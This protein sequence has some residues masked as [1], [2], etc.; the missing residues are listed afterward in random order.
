MTHAIFMNKLGSL[1]ETR[2]I[3]DNWSEKPQELGV[4]I[5]FCSWGLPALETLSALLVLCVETVEQGFPSQRASDKEG[6]LSFYL[7]LAWTSYWKK[8][9][10]PVSGGTITLTILPKIVSITRMKLE[11]SIWN[12][13][14]NAS[15][16]AMMTSS[17]GNI[18]R[19]TGPLCGDFTGLRWIPRTKASDAEL[20]CFLW[21]APE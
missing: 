2:C 7:M 9:K 8:K 13:I 5:S 20:W 14:Q 4:S 18:Y 21:S 15:K 19:V 12:E 11:S 16:N 10:L 1:T 6:A 17:N 3:L